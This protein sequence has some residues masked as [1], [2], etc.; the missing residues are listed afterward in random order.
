MLV[1][2]LKNKPRTFSWLY[3]ARGFFC[4]KKVRGKILSKV[5][6]ILAVILFSL[7][8]TATAAWAAPDPVS[9]TAGSAIGQGVTALALVPILAVLVVVQAVMFAVMSFAGYLLDMAWQAN[10]SLNPAN[11]LVVQEGWRIM[12]DLANAFF[13]LIILWIAFTI[14]FNFENLGGRKLLVRVVVVALLI[15]FSLAMVTTVFGFTNMI[16]GIFASKIKDNDVAGIIVSATKF[17]TVVNQLSQA[18]VKQL[19]DNKRAQE[20]L[21]ETAKESATFT[22][23]WGTK[24]TL[25]AALGVKQANAQLLGGLAGCGFGAVFGSFIP[26]VGT[27]VGCVAGGISGAIVDSLLGI[28]SSVISGGIKLAVTTALSSLL[29]LFGAAGFALGAIALTIRLLVEV[30]LSILAPVALALHAIP[31][32]GVSKYWDQWLSTLLRWAF[33]APMFYFLFYMALFMLQTYDKAATSAQGS[34]TSINVIGDFDRILQI[35]VA[36]GFIFLA[37]KL[38]RKTGGVVAETAIDWGKKLGVAGVGLAGRVAMPAVG[39]AATAV[40]KGISGIESPAMRK[41]LALPLRG[42]TKVAVAG[43]RAEEKAK[44]SYGGWNADEKARALEAG[45]LPQA[46]RLA[47]MRGLLAERELGLIG[48]SRPDLVQETIVMEKRMGG[49]WKPYVR[50]D[51]TLAEE[52]YYEHREIETAKND[53]ATKMGGRAEDYSGKETALFLTVKSMR[54]EHFGENFNSGALKA[55]TTEGLFFRQVMHAT[56]RMEMFN[57]INQNDPS[58]LKALNDEL[59]ITPAEAQQKARTAREEAQRARSTGDNGLAEKQERLAQ[60]Y[61][62]AYDRMRAIIKRMDP[63]QFRAY[64]TSLARVLGLQ[65]PALTEDEK[66]DAIV[67]EDRQ[68]LALRNLRDSI[69]ELEIAIRDRN[70]LTAGSRG[71]ESAGAVIL[72]KTGLD[73]ERMQEVLGELQRMKRE[74]VQL[75]ETLRRPAT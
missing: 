61:D 2:F 14:I 65:M 58:A 7:T 16:A 48:K 10:I 44:K 6:L 75:G 47:L 70:R 38:S 66:P 35:V 39:A 63:S 49:D 9:S 64:D 19:A 18:D 21:E 1:N 51:P 74:E 11:M 4:Q 28:S 36:F 34:L 45:G 53:M 62:T 55:D 56:G 60:S 50:S 24:D 27:A 37:V 59:N 41:M 20:K 17:H 22:Q 73:A 54:P 40:G 13:I 67:R 8:L 33:F 46:D 72:Q 5:F 32:K 52:S 68:R 15:N 26:V 31:N 57:R 71:H 29:L 69:R 12:R 30:M 42:L 3:S 23:K 43:R 25:L